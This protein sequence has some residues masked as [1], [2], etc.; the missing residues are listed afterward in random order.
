M[1]RLASD[2]SAPFRPVRTKDLVGCD[3]IPPVFPAE[4]GIH[5][6]S[7][8]SLRGPLQSAAAWSASLDRTLTPL[9]CAV[10]VIRPVFPAKAGIH[11]ASP[12]VCAW[13][14]SIGDG[15][16]RIAQIEVLLPYCHPLL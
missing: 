7:R 9:P 13:P 5:V 1:S 2:A 11:V 12:G 4:A 16:E 10:D 15:L 8:V 14:V 6:A 3:A